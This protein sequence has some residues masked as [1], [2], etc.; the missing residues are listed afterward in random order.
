VDMIFS[1]AFTHADLAH[2][3]DAQWSLRISAVQRQ[4]L[5]PCPTIA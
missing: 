2:A 5:R 4:L 1:L 3:S